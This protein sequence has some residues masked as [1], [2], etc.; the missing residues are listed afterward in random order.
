MTIPSFHKPTLSASAIGFFSLLVFLLIFLCILVGQAVNHPY[1][2]DDPDTYWH[3]VVGR[4][5][6][7]TGSFPHKDRFSWTFEGQP[8]IAKEWLSQLILFAGYQLGSWR[9]VVL[10]AAAALAL[11]YALLFVILSRQMRITVAA[12][13][14]MVA[15][16]LALGHFLARPHVFS[17]PLIVL[18]VAGLVRAVEERRAPS[19]LLLPV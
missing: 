5:I 17:F 11:A 15:P 12:G 8:W 13:V 2:L 6:W 1:L 10:I 3:V 19:W 4:E 9:G 16:L 18:W 14:A 7:E